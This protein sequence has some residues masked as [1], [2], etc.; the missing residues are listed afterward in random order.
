MNP[1]FGVSPS[2]ASAGAWKIWL[3][4]FLYLFVLIAI[5][6]FLIAMGE[7]PWLYVLA[8]WPTLLLVMLTTGTGLV[9]Q[10]QSFRV[11]GEGDGPS[12]WEMTA[13]WS[14]S[15]VVSVIA[16]L[17]VGI[18]TRTA[19]LMQVGMTISSCVA[20]SLRQIWMGLEY[21]LLIAAASL[22]FTGWPLAIPVATGCLAGWLFMLIL[23]RWSLKKPD[24]MN[25]KR[26]ERLL[27]SLRKPVD[28]KGHPW[29]VMQILAMTATYYIAFN[30]LGA[31]L[32]IM[33]ALALAAL[34]VV[35]S[36]IVLV[37]NGLGITDALW[38]IVATYSGL[39]LEQAVA[40]A[41]TIRCAHLLASC[42]IYLLAVLATKLSNA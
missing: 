2:P 35:L 8:N 36:L 32:D 33:Q 37:P 13:I 17:F 7:L 30:S 28:L 24:M 39:S 25:Y 16:P 1:H 9:I 23:R 21:A 18:A 41:I 12:L 6:L 26:A 29:F 14:A 11:V 27:I 10:A 40:V 22:P 5:I 34:T 19:L 31:E 38:V 20:A 15:A 3:K 42:C 4:R